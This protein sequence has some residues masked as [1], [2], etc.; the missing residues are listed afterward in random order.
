VKY[1]DIKVSTFR[2]RVHL[3][4]VGSSLFLNTITG[5]ME[6]FVLAHKSPKGCKGLTHPDQCV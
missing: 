4:S 1:P 6:T 5:A 3:N 2:G